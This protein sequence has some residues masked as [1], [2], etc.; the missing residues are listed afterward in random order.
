M[1][2]SILIVD[3]DKY[4]V[5]EISDSLMDY[6]ITKAYNGDDALAALKK[7]NLIDLVILDY[8]MPGMTGIEALKRIKKID[9]DIGIIILTGNSS[10]DVAISALKAHADDYI[11]K[12]IN[13]EKLLIAIEDLLKKKERK[14]NET[15]FFGIMGKT[16]RVKDFIER[17]CF[18]KVGLKDAADIVCLSPKYLSRMF[19][20]FTGE[21]FSEY[22]SRI[23]TKK[24]KE[25]LTKTGFNVSQISDRL[26]YLNTESFSRLFKRTAGITAT[27]YRARKYSKR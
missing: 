12:P 2:Y 8:K 20:E 27:E 16:E 5:D 24:A 11:E 10:L 18:K 21:G 7:P 17:N 9:P 14:K 13:G 26:G 23:K 1:A 3:D 6:E 25:L 22:R 4:F 15:D 19:K